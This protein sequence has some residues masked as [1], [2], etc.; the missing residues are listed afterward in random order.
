[1]SFVVIALL[2]NASRQVM[3]CELDSNAAI[4]TKIQ[5]TLSLIY[6]TSYALFT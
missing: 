5:R 2:A 3:N 4:T 6:I 1:M